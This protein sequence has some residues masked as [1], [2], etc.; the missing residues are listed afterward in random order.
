MTKQKA[1]T[2]ECEKEAVRVTLT[3]VRTPRELAEIWALVFRR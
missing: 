1:F 3:S 2:K